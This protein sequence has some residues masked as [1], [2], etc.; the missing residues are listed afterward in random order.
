M[1]PHRWQP[2]RLCCP[3]DLPG[4][5]TG[6]AC[7][8]LLQHMKVKGKMKSLSH[9]RLF[10]TPWTVAYQA[11]LSMG[12]S[13]QDYWSGLPF[14]SPNICTQLCPTL[15]SPVESTLQGSSARVIFKQEYWSGVP[16]L[17]PGNIT[18]DPGI[19]PT[20]LALLESRFFTTGTS[21]EAH[22]TEPR[23]E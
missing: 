8:F 6:V 11:P 21:W 4:K 20:T 18:P 23:S 1:Q 10:V 7:H 9:V 15:C 17:T 13:R 22:T 19:K 16:H 12:V 5:I 3:W 14:P 2:T